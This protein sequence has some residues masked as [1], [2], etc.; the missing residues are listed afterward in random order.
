M[1]AEHCPTRHPSLTPA[2]IA[3]ENYQRSYREWREWCRAN[4]VP[5]FQSARE[6]HALE[7]VNQAHKLSM[8]KDLF[9]GIVE[10]EAV[11]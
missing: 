5:A 10:S 6:E 4:P 8:A 11:K 3:L 1:S 7:R 2:Q 9:I